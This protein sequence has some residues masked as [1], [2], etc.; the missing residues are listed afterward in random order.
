MKDMNHHLVP[1]KQLGSAVVACDDVGGEV[2]AVCASQSKVAEL[3]RK[4]AEVL[5]PRR[6]CD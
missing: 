6:R 4:E 1:H 5:L 2:F 3:R